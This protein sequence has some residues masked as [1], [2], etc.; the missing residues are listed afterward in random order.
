MKLASVTVVVAPIGASLSLGLRSGRLRRAWRG[1]S[2]SHALSAVST[3][4][5]TDVFPNQLATSFDSNDHPLGANEVTA[6]T[7]DVDSPFPRL[8]IAAMSPLLLIFAMGSKHLLPSADSDWTPVHLPSA[9]RTLI[10]AG[11]RYG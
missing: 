9:S 10:C 3:K 8:Q 1:Y 5:R 4:L 2:V 11:G 7:R 6:S